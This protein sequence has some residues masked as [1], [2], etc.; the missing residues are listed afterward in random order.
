VQYIV[1]VVGKREGICVCEVT[2]FVCEYAE[3]VD[4][5]A[6]YVLGSAVEG[7]A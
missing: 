7:L 6:D 1:S 3:E 5:T 4:F 2:R